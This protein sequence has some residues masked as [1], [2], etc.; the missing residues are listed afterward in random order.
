[1]LF[2]VVTLLRVGFIADVA[3]MGGC[4]GCDAKS[5]LTKSQESQPSRPSHVAKPLIAERG[6]ENGRCEVDDNALCVS[7]IDTPNPTLDSHGTGN[8]S[9]EFIN[10][11]LLLW[12][13]TRQ[14]WVGSK[15]KSK[16][17]DQNRE[18][19]LSRNATYENL[20]GSNKPFAKRVPLSEM[21]TF[22]VNVWEHEGKYN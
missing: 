3:C 15:R 19:K 22:L 4:F 5:K 11:G 2:V 6:E 9:Q 13:Q 10:H 21:V 16:Q 7:S 8:T 18:P 12:N 20:L 1:M 14:Q 17:T